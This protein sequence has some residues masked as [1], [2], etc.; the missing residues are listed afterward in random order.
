MLEILGILIGFVAIILLLSVIAT[1]LVQAASSIFRVRRWAFKEGIEANI[2]PRAAEAVDAL[3]EGLPPSPPPPLPVPGTAQPVLPAYVAR[4]SKAIAYLLDQPLAVAEKDSTTT[5]IDKSEF[6]NPLTAAGFDPLVVAGAE[7]RFEQMKRR[8]EDKFLRAMRLITLTCAVIVAVMFQVSTPHL[9]ESLLEDEELRMRAE[10]LGT[11]LAQAPDAAYQD[12]V[13]GAGLKART[14]FLKAHPDLTDDLGEVTVE[15]RS[16]DD[17]IADVETALAGEED[18]DTLSAEYRELVER[19][20]ADA[21]LS[22]LGRAG[23]KATDDLA[24][25]D[26]KPF[27]WSADFYYVTDP[28][29]HRKHFD[30]TRVLGL[31]V[32]AIL[33]SLGAP[34]W[35]ERLKELVGLKDALRKKNEQAQASATSTAK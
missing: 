29:T 24:G 25:L 1:A 19:A 16:V 4:D 33:V 18:P 28:G 34:F 21:D 30:F 17:L 31:L 13:V 15:A 2:M 26:I 8:M 20:L 23:L 12:I 22:S 27:D 9:L 10:A 3:L 5:W 7:K 32:T 11:Q 14:A 6:T 35:Y